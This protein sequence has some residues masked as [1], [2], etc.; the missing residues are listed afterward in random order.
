MA[1]KITIKEI[2]FYDSYYEVHCVF[3]LT[4]PAWQIGKGN[5]PLGTTKDVAKMYS[6]SG[7]S[8]EA[9][10]K[11]DLEIKFA[12]EQAILDADYTLA[13]WNMIWDGE[14]WA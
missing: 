3:T 11:A 8:T 5:P 12:E 13:Y 7:D 2:Q 4:V 14:V 6:Y 9:Q 1:T 10:T